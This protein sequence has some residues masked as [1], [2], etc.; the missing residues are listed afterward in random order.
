M[1]DLV[2]GRGVELEVPTFRERIMTVNEKPH[3]VARR[4]LES[5]SVRSLRA[6]AVV[7]AA[8]HP[9]PHRDPLPRYTY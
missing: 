5:V 6:L 3:G 7:D 8:A 1:S 2:I 4:V 9:S